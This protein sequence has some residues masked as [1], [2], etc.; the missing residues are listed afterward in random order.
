[1]IKLLEG[2]GA[3]L[4]SLANLDSTLSPLES[5]IMSRIYINA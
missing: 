4:V 5:E 1:M 3:E 2:K